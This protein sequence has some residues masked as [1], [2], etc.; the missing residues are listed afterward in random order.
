ML[1]LFL[2]LCSIAWS[3]VWYLQ[4]CSFCSLLS[5][6]FTVFCVSKWTLGWIYQSLWWMLLGFWWELCWPCGL[7]LVA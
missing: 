2:W 1:F 7:L 3:Q 4:C 5:W 6:L